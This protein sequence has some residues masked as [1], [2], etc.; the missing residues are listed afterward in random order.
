MSACVTLMV[1]LMVI[2]ILFMSYSE[3][4][5]H[6]KENLQVGNINQRFVNLKC[7][8]RKSVYAHHTTEFAYENYKC[9][10]NIHKK[11]P[12]TDT[13]QIRQ[14]QFQYLYS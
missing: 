14:R 3:G 9:I 11:S 12:I 6:L 7:L 1:L 10:F 5:N 8:K 13:V 4:V 2:V